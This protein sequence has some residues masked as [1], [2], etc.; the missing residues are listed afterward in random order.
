MTSLGICD[1]QCGEARTALVDDV[2]QK[3]CAKLAAPGPSATCNV[4]HIHAHGHVDQGL[5]LARSRNREERLD[6]HLEERHSMA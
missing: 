4:T 2:C 6:S 5:D 1:V 3:V